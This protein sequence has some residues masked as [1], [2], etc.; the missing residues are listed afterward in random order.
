M[1]YKDIGEE[2]L[3]HA[4]EGRDISFAATQ[5]HWFPVKLSVTDRSV[6]F[7]FTDIKILLLRL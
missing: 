7:F 4:F 5:W 6:E 2:M 3:E 1:V